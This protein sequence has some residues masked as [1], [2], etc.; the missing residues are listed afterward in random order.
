MDC[1][2]PRGAHTRIEERQNEGFQSRPFSRTERSQATAQL[3]QSLSMLVLSYLPTSFQTQR[4]TASSSKSIGRTPK[5][6]MLRS[7]QLCNDDVTAGKRHQQQCDRRAALSSRIDTRQCG[8]HRSPPSEGQAQHQ[9]Q[10]DARVIN[11]LPSPGLPQ[12]ATDS[13]TLRESFS[14]RVDECAVQMAGSPRRS[15]S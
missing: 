4:R 1:S 12:E 6:T 5:P 7:I 15:V 2:T 10:I 3:M 8:T 13:S 14:V 9:R 11:E